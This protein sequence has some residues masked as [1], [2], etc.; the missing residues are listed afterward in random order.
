MK[1]EIRIKYFLEDNKHQFETFEIAIALF[2]KKNN[3]GNF[4]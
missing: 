3:T 1:G 2:Q 4:L